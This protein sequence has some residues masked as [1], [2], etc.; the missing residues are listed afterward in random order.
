MRVGQGQAAG[1]RGAAADLKLLG[2][3]SGRSCSSAFRMRGMTPDL[4]K[5]RDS[6]PTLGPIVE[7]L[8]LE[9]I[10]DPSWGEPS[11]TSYLT[12]DDRQNPDI[13]ANVEAMAETNRLISWFGRDAE[14]Y[15][16]LWRGPRN[17]D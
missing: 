11:D 17:R 7:R 6:L 16:G 4:V 8:E 15:L 12:D 13:A 5:L 3:Q 2:R 1:P 9:L 10:D 14:G